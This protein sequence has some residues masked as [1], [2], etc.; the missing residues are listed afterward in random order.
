MPPE[1]P[2]EVSLAVLSHPRFIEHCPPGF[3]PERPRRLEAAE[4]GARRALEALGRTGV[5]VPL[6][7][8]TREELERVHDGAWLDRLERTLEGPAGYLDADTYF[9]ASTRGAAWLAAGSACALVESLLSGAVDVGML[10]ARPPGHHATRTRAMGFCVLNNVAVA[11]AHALSLG[12]SRVAI[13][14]WDV[15]HGNGTQDIFYDHPGVLFVSL[16]ESPAYPDTGYVHE[17][18]G[19]RAPGMTV[20]LPLPSGCDGGAYVT[21]FER[22]VLPVLTEAAPD[23]VLISAGYDAHTRDPLATMLLERGDYGWM[24]ARLADVAR[25]SAKGR[26]GVLLEGGYDLSALEEGVEDTLLGLANPSA[27]PRPQETSQSRSA[28]AVVRAVERAQRPFWS[29]LR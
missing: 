13:V 28:D 22:V 1:T 11:A 9:N 2:A 23:L 17:T 4:L 18:G 27:P 3:H 7:E 26:V 29:S 15:H 6:R 25:A 19:P 20:N 8:A 5:H 24:A 12:A 21:A 14:D 10:L 16:H